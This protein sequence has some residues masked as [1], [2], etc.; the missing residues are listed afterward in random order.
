VVADDPAF[1][2]LSEVKDTLK[3][4]SV[5]PALTPRDRILVP[6]LAGRRR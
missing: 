3:V 1:Q 6:F 2:R 4:R 5:R